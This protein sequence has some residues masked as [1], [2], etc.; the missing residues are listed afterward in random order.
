MI[1]ID[2]KKSVGLYEP[3]WIDILDNSEIQQIHSLCN[4]L[5]NEEGKT[6]LPIESGYRKSDVKW[7]PNNQET[8]W[9]YNKVTTV[10]RQLNE[11]SYNFQLTGGE[12]F[13]Y[14]KYS[15]ANQGEYKW[16]TDTAVHTDGCVRKLSIVILLSDI[17]EFE[18]GH[19]MFS[20][21]GSSEPAPQKKGR[22]F[23]F[24][25]WIP[26]CV[27]PVIKGVRTSLVMWLYGD[28]LK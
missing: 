2:F 23:L 3:Q 22:M 19:F 14:T 27:T 1:D 9:L 18:G 17:S 7:I 28:Q 13:Q 20:R 21:I 24:P 26:H 6:L 25:S 10:A 5:K 11:E 15:E 12:P 8:Y 16:H 4:S